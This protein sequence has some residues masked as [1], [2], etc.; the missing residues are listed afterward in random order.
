MEDISHFGLKS[1]GKG[2]CASMLTLCSFLQNVFTFVRSLVLRV[3]KKDYRHKA[4]IYLAGCVI[5]AVAMTSSGFGGGGRNV[6]TAFAETVSDNSPEQEESEEIE[7]ITEAEE[8]Q[9]QIQERAEAA[10]KEAR[11][12]VEASREARE[13]AE[14]I[15]EGPG[16]SEKTQNQPGGEEGQID[17][18]V[19]L[20]AES[21]E[22]E[23][24]YGKFTEY[25]DKDYQVLLKIVQAEAGI[26]DAKG[27]ILVANVVLNRVRSGEFPNTIS[28]VVYQ[29][30]QFSPVQDGSLY[31]CRVTDETVAC[32]NRALQGEDYSQGA[33]YFM[34][35]S[36]ARSKAS[37][38]FDRNLTFL[39]KHGG[40]EFFK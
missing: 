34:N 8:E 11:L 39:F 24:N 19:S 7:N 2:E 10:Q 28:E 33:L 18:A 25:S 30:G 17:E 3:S 23:N 1:G 21:T 14:K 9:K 22:E 36:G 16:Y 37:R 12:A 32:V 38:W 40:H 5:T 13:I 15:K 26:C 29:S 6:I 35:R 27:K 31:S 4:V 20:E